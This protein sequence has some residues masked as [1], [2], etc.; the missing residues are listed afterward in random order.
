MAMRTMPQGARLTSF[1]NGVEAG[2]RVQGEKATEAKR[3]FSLRRPTHSQERMRKK[4]SVC[5][6]RNDGVGGAGCHGEPNNAA[7]R[8]ANSILYPSPPVF[9]LH[10]LSKPD[11]QLFW[12]IKGGVRY[13]G[14]FWWEGSFGKDAS[15]K[16]VSDEKI[17]TAVTFLKHIDALP[18]AVTGGVA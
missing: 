7:R 2:R 8:E 18:P 9:A 11:Y 14:M 12:I 16:D 1:G 13:A 6:V 3:D 17:W 10:P 5:S 4:K 15:G